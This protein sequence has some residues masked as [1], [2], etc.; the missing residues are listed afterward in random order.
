MS[1]RLPL[2]SYGRRKGKRLSP[3]K[4]RLLM[5]LLPR[6][7]LDLGRPAPRDLT[8]LFPAPVKQVWLEIGFGSGEHL[9][10][11]A[12]AHRDVGFIGCEPF[13]NGVASLLG[14]IETKGVEALRLHDG[15][16]RD[17]LSWL[18]AAS[19][20]RAFV[21]FPDPWP[22]KRQSKRR[23]VAPETVKALARVMKPGG[24]FRFAS[25]NGE[26]ASQAL[27]V[28]KRSG[29]FRWLAECADDWRERPTDWPETRYARKALSEGREPIYL[30]WRRLWR[31]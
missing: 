2:K 13:V 1:E 5:E 7:R 29:A 22:K 25:D 26:Y 10:G 3:R 6:L 28:I 15:D 24:E 30:R 20:G 17:V 14:V 8:S 19:I 12:E 11:Q 16:A 31:I 18:P 21:L 9:L 27:L 4:E 23:L